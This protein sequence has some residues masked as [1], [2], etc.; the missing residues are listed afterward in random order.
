MTYSR[1]N[2]SPR[3]RQLMEF[4]T[5]LH[6]GGDPEHDIPAEQMFSGHSL[7]PHVNFLKKLFDGLAVRSVLDYGAGKADVYRDVAFKLPDGTKVRGVQPYWG[8]DEVA[9]YDPGYA[10]YA[11]L[12]D[13]RFHAVIC[14]DVMEHIPEQDLDWV[15]D[16]L[17]DH[18]ERLVYACI[19]TYP[20]RKVFPDGSNVHVTL[21][22]AGWWQALFAARKAALQSA[23]DFVL[24]VYGSK[25]DKKP[26]VLT[27]FAKQD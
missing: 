16:E 23:A 18:A 17:F 15:I 26:V 1:A 8:V 5:Q 25:A 12:P 14:T 13:R 27:S 21:K 10:P 24:V 7:L 20:A 22:E 6:D 9:L 11:T 3:Y 4:Y 19:S 2:P